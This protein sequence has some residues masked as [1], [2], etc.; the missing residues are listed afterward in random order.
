[1]QFEFESRRVKEY[2]N[3]LTYQWWP[4]RFGCFSA[5]TGSQT[6]FDENCLS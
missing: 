1:M 5:R 4:K 6:Y 2:G 3:R